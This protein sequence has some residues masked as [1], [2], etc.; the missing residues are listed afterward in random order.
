MWF[1]FFFFFKILI[2]P[3]KLI[4]FIDISFLHY[5][6]FTVCLTLL[7]PISASLIPILDVDIKLHLTMIN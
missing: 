1:F 5:D 2:Q 4:L 3:N 6:Y 7:P